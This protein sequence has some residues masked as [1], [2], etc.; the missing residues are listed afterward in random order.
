MKV[1]DMY[2]KFFIHCRHNM[3][4]SHLNCYINARHRPM[5][6]S[7][8]HPQMEDAIKM[9]ELM[10]QSNVQKPSGSS[11]IEVNCSNS[12]QDSCFIEHEEKSEL[13]LS[14]RFIYYS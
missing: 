9:R 10:E 6:P 14:R 1:C 11:C 12:S 3:S 5:L 13:N 8:T 7:D 4:C 2:I